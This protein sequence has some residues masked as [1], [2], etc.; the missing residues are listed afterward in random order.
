MQMPGRYVNRNSQNNVIVNWL[1]DDTDEDS[2]F[3]EPNQ[4]VDVIDLTQD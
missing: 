4:E 1:M 3:G 2:E